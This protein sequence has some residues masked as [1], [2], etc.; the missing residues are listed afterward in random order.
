MGT[1]TWNLWDIIACIPGRN[2]GNI[3]SVRKGIAIVDTEHH[4]KICQTA[5]GFEEA[6]MDNLQSVSEVKQTVWT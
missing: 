5:I 6:Y 3:S 1:Y 2:T 4:L